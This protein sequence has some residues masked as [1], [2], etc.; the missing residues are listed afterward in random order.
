VNIK[1]DAMF[2]DIRCKLY[3]F[4]RVILLILQAVK[5]IWRAIGLE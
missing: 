1:K 3:R 2:L 5:I 4:G